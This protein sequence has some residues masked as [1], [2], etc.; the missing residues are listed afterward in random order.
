[1]ILIQALLAPILLVLGAMAIAASVWGVR[2]KMHGVEGLML[3]VSGAL[4]IVSAVR[5]FASIYFAAGLMA[6]VVVL[7]LVRRASSDGEAQ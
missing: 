1:M 5:A 3:V 7:R 6:L 4:V 2:S